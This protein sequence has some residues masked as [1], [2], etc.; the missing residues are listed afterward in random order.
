MEN[1]RQFLKTTSDWKAFFYK[2]LRARYFI[3]LG[4]LS[5]K[6]LGRG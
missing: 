4:A 3:Y 1:S 5:V 2:V 6:I